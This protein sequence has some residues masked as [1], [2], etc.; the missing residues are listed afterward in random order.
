MRRVTQ[1][2]H[3][4]NFYP[5]DACGDAFGHF[6]AIAQVRRERPAVSAEKIAVHIRPPV[7]DR[8]RRE[9]RRAEQ[10]RSVDDVRLGADV[11]GKKIL[12]VERKKIDA[13]QI[14]HRLRRGIN[15]HRISVRAKRPQIVEAHDVVGVRMRVD[16]SIERANFFPQTL[17]AKIRARVHDPRAL[18]RLDVN[19]RAQPL[20][21]RIGGSADFA[22]ATDHWHALRSARSEKRD[23]EFR[24][25]LKNAGTFA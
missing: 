11:A 3:D 12:A 22:V 15:R 13:P 24:H 23:G 17:R 2:V 20:V 14:V 6:L 19:R 21:A 5:R 1:S 18:R 10:E 25:V 9:F 4:E 7:F 8:Q 16:D